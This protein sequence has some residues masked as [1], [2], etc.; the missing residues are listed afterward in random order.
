MTY[1]QKTYKKCILVKL[2][3]D[4]LKPRAKQKQKVKDYNYK[5]KILKEWRD[6]W[7]KGQYESKQ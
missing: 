4:P 2:S 1:N 3:K 5:G 6:G 7:F